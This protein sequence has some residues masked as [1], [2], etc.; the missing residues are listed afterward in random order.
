MKLAWARRAQ[1]DLLDLQEFARLQPSL[2]NRLADALESACDRIVSFP[3][4]GRP[5]RIEGTRE[6]VLSGTPCIAA[7]KIEATRVTILAIIHGARRWPKAF[8]NGHEQPAFYSPAAVSL[9]I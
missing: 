6:V 7:Y 4:S 3:E 8:W 1:H 5:G 2:G 9:A